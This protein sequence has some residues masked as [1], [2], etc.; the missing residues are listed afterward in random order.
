MDPP[1]R[2][3]VHKSTLFFVS[4]AAQVQK[5]LC[6]FFVK[7]ALPNFF[8]HNPIIP[9]SNSLP[10]FLV[11]WKQLLYTLLRSF[12]IFFR[13]RRIVDKIGFK[14]LAF[15]SSKWGLFFLLDLNHRRWSL[16]FSEKNAQK[17]NNCYSHSVMDILAWDGQR[18]PSWRW[19]LCFW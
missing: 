19:F 17:V 10:K 4:S 9:Y 8:N 6:S 5:N 18:K 14:A 15:Y 11:F 2:S 1:H 7:N 12:M 3:V 16:R 13:F